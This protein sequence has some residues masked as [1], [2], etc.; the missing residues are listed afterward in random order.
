MRSI[1]G[2]TTLL[3]FSFSNIALAAPSARDAGDSSP[4][5]I[6][7]IL[8]G[9][10]VFW[11]IGW[12]IKQLTG[13]GTARENGALAFLFL[14][15]AGVALAI[16]YTVLEGFSEAPFLTIAVVAFYWWFLKHNR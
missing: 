4:E 6:P 8:A 5:G 3:S 11:C 9:M 13:S 1:V 7:M 12:T 14:I 2:L 10:V 15:G 16:G